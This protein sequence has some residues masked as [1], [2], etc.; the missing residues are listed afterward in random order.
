VAIDA[1]KRVIDYLR[2]SV[3][4]RCNLR[5]V[6]CMPAEGIPERPHDEILSYEEIHRFARVAVAQGIT[7]IRLTGGEPLVRKGLPA[8]VERLVALPGVQV[9]LTTNGVLL[10]RFAR[11]LREAGLSRVNVSLDSLDPEMF[12]R[13][14]RL[15]TLSDVLTGIEAAVD[16]GLGPV[17]VNVVVVRSLGQDLEAFAE[18][19]RRLPIHVRFIEYMPVGGKPLW[20]DED[21]VPAEEIQARLAR[22]FELE[23]ASKRPEGWG[24]AHYFR[25]P[26]A[27]GT[28]GFITPRSSHF[29]AEC[30][31]LRLTADGKLRTCLFSEEMIDV[32]AVLRSTGDD[33]ALAAV[34]RDALDKKP[35]KRPDVLATVR[36]MSQIGG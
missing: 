12:A 10:A 20:G 25:L 9:A 29:C 17:K 13:L 2:I 11:E 27:P 36:P 35:E 14:T 26:D 21:F 24:P 3:T 34:I 6:Y 23:P 16:A 32:R 30:N 28:V 1:H 22:S 33:D 7:R 4:D 31:R 5:C 15:G 19:T 18:M 8:F